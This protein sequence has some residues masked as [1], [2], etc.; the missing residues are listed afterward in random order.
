MSKN[1]LPKTK[2]PIKNIQQFISIDGLDPESI[3]ERKQLVNLELNEL[4]IDEGEER[5]VVA[6]VTV[7]KVDADGDI[8]IP[9]GA[10]LERF[11]KNPI[12]YY[13]H[14]YN[15][16]PVGKATQILVK[17][18]KI[19]MKVVFAT[20]DFAKDVWTLFKEGVLRGFSLGFLAKKSLMRGTKAF[21]NYV[22]EKGLQIDETVQRIITEFQ[23]FENSVA[24]LPSNDDALVQAISSKSFVPSK[25][26]IK[27]LQLED[28][29][30]KEDTV[31]AEITVSESEK[32]EIVKEVID[33]LN[34]DSVE[35]TKTEDG[36]VV[37]IKENVV[38]ETLENKIKEKIEAVEEKV[39]EKVPDLKGVVL[40]NSEGEI[41]GEVKVIKPEDFLKVKKILRKGN[42]DIGN[43]IKNY[44][45]KR[46]GKIV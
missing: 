38:K 31:I 18:D 35:I 36:A 13:S 1:K 15:L 42:Y 26:T 32:E 16:L 30:T 39:E 9:E 24:G 29:I 4:V 21:N 22:K 25:E 45:K 19:Q 3:V 8:V 41:N 27:V 33:E 11:Q 6:N 5:T 23:I 37:E 34:E 44:C 28:I 12:I 43:E 2:F 17:E 20:T 40:E 14:K 46:R 7:M 10:D